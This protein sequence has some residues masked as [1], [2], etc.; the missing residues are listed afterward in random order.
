MAS[1]PSF[2]DRL[3]CLPFLVV[4]VSMRH[5][6]SWRGTQHVSFLAGR[7]KDFA[8]LQMHEIDQDIFIIIKCFHDRSKPPLHIIHISK[9][10]SW[11]TLVYHQLL[12]LELMFSIPVQKNKCRLQ[13]LS[14]L[15]E[16]SQQLECNGGDYG[17]QW[18][19][20]LKDI[21]ISVDLLL[22]VLFC[23]LCQHRHSC[24]GW[25]Q[26]VPLSCESKVFLVMY[27]ITVVL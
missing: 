21:S 11:T 3:H 10:F 13:I 27:K 26:E 25:W 7:W 16:F 14:W 15:A 9:I 22:L 23:S 24:C 20:L 1:F 12:I 6:T 18:L 2:L 19:L 4:G 17:Y 8:G 5:S